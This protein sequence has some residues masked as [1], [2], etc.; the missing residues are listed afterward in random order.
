MAAVGAPTIRLTVTP[1]DAADATRGDAVNALLFYGGGVL[2]GRANDVQWLPLEERRPANREIASRFVGHLGYVSS[3]AT[4]VYRSKRQPRGDADARPAPRL[5]LSGSFDKT[6]RVWALEAGKTITTLKGGGAMH[7]L[8]VT[9][10]QTRVLAVAHDESVYWWD[11]QSGERGQYS[12]PAVA[13]DLAVLPDDR[14]A[15]ALW[16]GSVRLLDAFSGETLHVASGLGSAA[17]YRIRLPAGGAGGAGAGC[18]IAAGATGELL[19]LRADNLA[20]VRRVQAHAD[21][22]K[23]FALA[24][25]G[26][27]ER[28]YAGAVDGTVAVHCLHSG[29]RLGEMGDHTRA[30]TSSQVK[31]SQVKS[32]QGETSDQSRTWHSTTTSSTSAERKTTVLALALGAD[33]R[34]RQYVASGGA[35]GS[36]FVSLLREPEQLEPT[37]GLSEPER[38]EEEAVPGKGATAEAPAEEEAVEEEAVE[39]EAVEEEAAVEKEVVEEVVEEEMVAEVAAAE[40]EGMEEEATEAPASV[41]GTMRR[42]RSRAPPNR[43]NRVA[44]KSTAQQAAAPRS[45]A[46]SRKAA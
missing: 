14:I 39:E 9:S 13:M 31:T 7:G 45:T 44:R 30:R 8:A 17:L 12:L 4:L 46:S 5:L 18:L 3:L 26:V 15:C 10:E 19:W 22:A 40:E 34:Q 41:P 6:V 29:S 25:D 23:I 38:V 16:D 35:D 11:F 36:C 43:W 24:V 20:C 37:T 27:G 33:G 32:S 1:L 42:Q 2:V 21:G 28:V